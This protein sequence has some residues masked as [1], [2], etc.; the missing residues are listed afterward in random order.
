MQTEREGGKESETEKRREGRKEEERAK[1][2][3]KQSSFPR[4]KGCRD[5]L[6]GF[7]KEADSTAASSKV[8][9]GCSRK[10]KDSMFKGTSSCS[11][12]SRAGP[13]IPPRK[14]MHLLNAQI[15]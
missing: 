10:R 12:L 8:V 5:V 6:Q 15:S 11:T 2:R 4:E 3:E 7:T 14:F 1:A 13:L 9:R